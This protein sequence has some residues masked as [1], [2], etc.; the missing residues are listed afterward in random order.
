MCKAA[1]RTRTMAV[2]I[3]DRKLQDIRGEYLQNIVVPHGSGDADDE[4]VLRIEP[5]DM[6]ITHDIPLAARLVEKGAVVLDDR[7]N[8][9]TPENIRE[10]LSIRDLMEDFRRAGLPTDGMGSPGEREIRAFAGTLDREL[11]RMLKDELP[12]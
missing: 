3:S 8:L 11:T 6:A 5:G 7:G 10:R 9:F 4:L 2:F 1:L 12:R